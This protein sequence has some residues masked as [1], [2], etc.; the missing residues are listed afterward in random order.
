[1]TKNI[2]SLSLTSNVK[3]T[4]SGT[5]MTTIE[6]FTVYTKMAEMAL[7][8]SNDLTTAKKATSSGARPDA[9]DYYWV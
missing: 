1:M 9:R 2:N 7:L 6:F 4:Q 8:A 3:L 5:K